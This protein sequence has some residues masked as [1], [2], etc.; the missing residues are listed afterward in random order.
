MR[1]LMTSDVVGG[2][3]R[4]ARDL[5]RGLV[6]RGHAVTVAIL[7]PAPSPEQRRGLTGFDVVAMDHPLDWTA[8]TA[9]EVRVTSDALAR[10]AAVI[11]VDIVH[12]H[13][14]A[15]GAGGAF[16]APV[17]AVC[18]SCV[19]T[20]W[21][22][23]G[24]GPLPPDLV[25]RAGLTRTGCQRADAVIAPTAAFAAAIARAYGL[26]RPPLV[27]RNGRATRQ[28]VLALE[29]TPPFVFTVGRLW[30]RAKNIAA[31][32]KAAARLAIPVLAAGSVVGQNGER[33]A[34]DHL[35]TL[36]H[37]DDA[38]IGAMLDRLPIFA[39]LARYEPFGLAVL[40]AAQAGCPLVLSNIP[41]F[42]ELWDGAALF[43]DPDDHDAAAAAIQ[44]LVDTPSAGAVLGAK[45]RARSAAYGV[46]AMVEGVLDVFHG[47]VSPTRAVG[48]RAGGIA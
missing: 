31:L 21:N 2:V 44:G 16:P 22:V 23:C 24:D 35:K 41:T 18:H 13:A 8:E 14:P 9:A 36:G 47:L 37:L 12:L 43:V 28:S 7:G 46:D 29:A 3:W 38:T 11:D 48:A 30:D 19:G 25:W 40:E 1:V 4:Y 42:R 26:S 33:A 5:A 15:L 32:D 17:V 27:V 6:D 34:F 20:W 39:S 45:A 10:L